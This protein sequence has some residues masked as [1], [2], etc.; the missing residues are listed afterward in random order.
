MTAIKQPFVTVVNNNY[1]EADFILRY[2]VIPPP[3]R[4]YDE[5]WKKC[6][7]NSVKNSSH[8]SAKGSQKQTGSSSR[9]TSY[10]QSNSEQ[11]NSQTS[12]P[13]S[14]KSKRSNSPRKQSNQ[15]SPDDIYYRL[16]GRTDFKF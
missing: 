11:N 1:D 4:N 7:V 2:K 16:N 6:P 10:H 13:K 8:T 14:S 3:P 5:I 12:S 15:Q 9:R